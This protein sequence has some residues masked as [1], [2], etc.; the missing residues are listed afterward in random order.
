MR[1]SIEKMTLQ[2]FIS[3]MKGGW[4]FAMPFVPRIAGNSLE[5]I[6][7]DYGEKEK[8]IE[9]IYR[10]YYDERYVFVWEVRGISFEILKS[11]YPEIHET[12]VYQPMEDGFL[13][14]LHW[15]Q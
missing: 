4:G 14:Q 7:E 10:S 11:L 6:F 3:K 12:N 13:I 15:P 9:V 8:E 5:A 1:T 2:E